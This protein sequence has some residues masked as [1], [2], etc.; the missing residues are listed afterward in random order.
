MSRNKTRNGRHGR[1]ANK[2]YQGATAAAAPCPKCDTNALFDKHYLVFDGNGPPGRQTLFRES[3]TFQFHNPNAELVWDVEQARAI[4][5]AHPRLPILVN[6]E[7]LK[8][9][10][11]EKETFVPEH[12]DHIPTPKREQPGILLRI[13]H[14][15]RPDQPIEWLPILVDGSHRAALALRDGRDFFAYEL[16]EKEQYSIC[17][18]TPEGGRP[19]KMPLISSCGCKYTWQHYAALGHASLTVPVGQ[20][21]VVLPLIPSACALILLIVSLRLIS[22]TA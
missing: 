18:Y 2:L 17:T 21:V 12:L 14:A 11:G 3:F 5:A 6:S 9:W 19:G 15:Q 22:A 1:A 10:L 16:T 20:R 4:L 13:A 7:W 8:A